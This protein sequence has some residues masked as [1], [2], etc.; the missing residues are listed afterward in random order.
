MKGFLEPFARLLAGLSW[1]QRIGLMVLVGSVVAGFFVVAT[2]LRQPDYQLLYG[3]LPSTEAGRIVER[4]RDQKIPYQVTNGG[5][6]ILIPAENVYE[7]RLALAGEGLPEGGHLG[8]EVFDRSRLG[9]GRFT[10]QVFFQR[11]LQGELGRTIGSLEAVKQARIHLVLKD[12]SVFD[13]EKSQPS[14]SV[15]LWLKP[16]GRMGREQ[17]QAIVHL[18]AGSV[19]GL[20]PERVVVV[21]QRGVLLSGGEKDK[22]GGFLS[23]SQF[24]HQRQYES[25]LEKGVEEMLEQ[26]LGPN[27]AIVRVSA[28]MDF[29]RIEEV[30][31]QFDP[32][33]LAIRSEQRSTESSR[34][35]NQDTQAAA[36]Q[37]AASGQA[38]SS[39][40]QQETI[41]YELNKLTRRLV[42]PSGRVRRLSVAVLVDGR[43]EAQGEGAPT[44]VPRTEEE[45]K[46]YEKLVKD[47]VGF[48]STRGDRVTVVNVAFQRSEQSASPEAGAEVEK[49]IKRRFWI[50]TAQKLIGII[51]IPL[52]LIFLV[53]RPLLKWITSGLPVTGGAP[54]SYQLPKTVGQLEADMGLAPGSAA[55]TPLRLRAVEMAKTDPNRTAQLA[56]SWLKDRRG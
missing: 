36:G 4:L 48:D 29:R 22:G 39:T 30:E 9:M 49:L 37:P 28:D 51:L 52:L 41:N 32:E 31:E 21:D 12:Q 34:K 7:M 8:F 38:A 3:D 55:E 24:Q 14:A 10:Q 40:K 42:I 6:N 26:A 19:R 33:K 54:A 43:Y 45:I 18:V 56:K 50:A 17:V 35:G 16:G 5:R 13:N 53:L 15:V 47:A 2:W 27:T 11:A 20:T 23:G 46:T 25:R 1:G 44:Y